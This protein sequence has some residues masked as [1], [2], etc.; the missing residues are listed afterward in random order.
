MLFYQ[1]PSH[2]FLA[3]SAGLGADPSL[4]DLQRRFCT[5]DP[6]V[7]TLW[8]TGPGPPV[9]SW[10]KAKY[11]LLCGSLTLATRGQSSQV[12]VLLSTQI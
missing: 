5:P 11:W 3:I 7:D 1:L 6:S 9:F 4:P 8:S 2:A 10:A 12:L